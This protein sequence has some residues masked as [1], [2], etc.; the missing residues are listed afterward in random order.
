MTLHA[1]PLMEEVIKVIAAGAASRT[2]GAFPWEKNSTKPL[3]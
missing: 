3:V 2:T 1:Q